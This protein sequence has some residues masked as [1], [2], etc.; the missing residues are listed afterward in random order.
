MLV[1]GYGSGNFIT[2]KFVPYLRAGF[3]LQV[4]ALCSLTV[5]FCDSLEVGVHQLTELEV[6]IKNKHC[7][8]FKNLFI[9][10]KN[11]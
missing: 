8:Y 4:S 11:L 10:F 6:R 9:Y 1:V 5:N 7:S 2:L 3:F